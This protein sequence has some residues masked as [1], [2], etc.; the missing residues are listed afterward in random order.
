MLFLNTVTSTT[1]F[2][3]GRKHP[4]EDAHSANP[5]QPVI[6]PFGVWTLHSIHVQAVYSYVS[7]AAPVQTAQSSKPFSRIWNHPGPQATQGNKLR[8][9]IHSKSMSKQATE[10][11]AQC[12]LSSFLMPV[13]SCYRST[14]LLKKEGGTKGWGERER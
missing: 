4:R 12:V 10:T 3:K 6:R 14:F 13:K 9:F 1:E 5:F 7:A 8:D 11:A 2:G